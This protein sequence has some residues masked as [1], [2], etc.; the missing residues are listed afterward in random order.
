MNRASGLRT[1]LSVSAGYTLLT[2]LFTYP[3]W[4]HPFTAV[5]GWRGDSWEYCWKL[6][7]FKDAILSGHSLFYAP[8]IF[9][10]F[11]YH[12]A[13][14]EITPAMMIVGLPFA[15]LFSEIVA[16]NLLVFGSFV[17]AGVLMFYL[18]R[19]ITGDLAASFL[20]GVLFA[21]SPFHMAHSLG[22]LPLMGYCWLPYLFWALY[23]QR[24]S[25]QAR[26]VVHAA[27]AFALLFYSS[28][29][30]GMIAAV[31]IVT[32]FLAGRPP[33]RTWGSWL[34]P[35]AGSVALGVL[36]IL[37][38]AWFF[39]QARASG[40]ATGQWGIKA[41]RGAPF[42]SFLLPVGG[43]PFLG[44][45]NPALTGVSGEND[46]SYGLVALVLAIWAL[47]NRHDE[48]A[49][50]RGLAFLVIV[51]VVLGLGPVA[52]RTSNQPWELPIA[53]PARLRQFARL[54]PEKLRHL[55]IPLPGAI[56]AVLPFF[57]G[58]RVWQRFAILGNVGIA[59]LAGIGYQRLRTGLSKRNQTLVYAGV[60]AFTILEFAIWPY[61]YS[62]PGPRAVDRWLASIPGRFAILEL[63]LEITQTGG[64]LYYS[65]FHGKELAVGCTTFPPAGYPEQVALFSTLPA[66][67]GVD[68]LRDINV[69]YVLVDQRADTAGHVAAFEASPDFHFEQTL[70]SVT[71]FSVLPESARL[72]PR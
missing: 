8:Q 10:P 39:V 69:R 70:D 26:Y 59:A 2:F 50:L 20:A 36:L 48:P 15:F 66:Q 65:R 58:M 23:R 19:A 42:L 27:I 61:P 31:G 1:L 68:R 21:F 52:F 57:S 4:R 56:L 25:D 38:L 11:G 37:P 40:V 22:H 32:W 6:W 51:G 63:P 60:L 46:V 62:F 3:W 34:K 49:L 67:A 35:V 45:L 71:V 5:M 55:P 47:R 33:G 30:L 17:M 72:I 7:W 41:M 28:L 54:S 44:W 12:L 16:F 14:G 9:V 29:Y 64:F 43:N 13:G 18:V 53:I 24:E